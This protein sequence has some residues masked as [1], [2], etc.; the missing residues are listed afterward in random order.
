MNLAQSAEFLLLN[1]EELRQRAKRGAIP[2]AKVG[3]RWV[4][5]EEDLVEHVRSLYPSG[6]QALQ[7]T[8]RKETSCHFADATAPGMST[9]PPQT[10][11]EYA[12]LLG[13]P[14]KP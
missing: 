8:K 10:G 12:D 14:V 6:W 4:F 13:L 7:V 5:L 11:S 1:P 2:G 3:R 9:S